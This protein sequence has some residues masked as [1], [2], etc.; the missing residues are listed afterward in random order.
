VQPEGTTSGIGGRAADR[1][2]GLDHQEDRMFRTSLRPYRLMGSLM[3]ALLVVA[4]G[5]GLLAPTIYRPFLSDGLV[6]FQSL[7]DVMA[8]LFAPLLVAAMHG[9]GR[10]SARAFV[11][12]VGLLVGVVYYY[13]FAVFDFFYTVYYPLYLALVGLGVY[14][15]IGL[16]TGVDAA[17]FAGRVSRRM[18][19]RLIAGVLATT[20][21]FVPI[22][23]VGIARGI[24]A[25]RPGQMDLVFVLDLCFLIPACLVAA[26]QVWRRRP[27]GYLLSGPLLV[28]A[29]VSGIL[30]S[31]GEVQKMLRGQPP[32]VEELGIY[33]LLAVVGSVSVVLY[34][35]S[36]QGG[37]REGARRDVLGPLPRPS[38]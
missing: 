8:L 4:A 3:A 25:Q 14:S 2:R 11:A 9:T 5:G 16:L 22:W 12:W 38:A 29:A 18:P 35:R 7:Q 20:L 23:S 37:P 27:A 21:L 36:L 13:A 19:V 10:G 34:L 30:L 17:A 32:T 31:A 28:K 15:L 33:L 6:A 1:H 26:V 24:A